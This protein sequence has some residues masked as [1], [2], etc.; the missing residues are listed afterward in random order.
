M[1]SFID[2]S[3]PIIRHITKNWLIECIP[4]LNNI[5]D[6]ILEELITYNCKNF[7]TF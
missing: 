1:L 2:D 7:V 4:Y 6:P 5:L 3:N